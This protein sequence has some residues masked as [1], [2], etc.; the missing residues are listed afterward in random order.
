MRHT[1]E[2]WAAGFYAAYDVVTDGRKWIASFLGT[3][4]D[5]NGVPLLDFPTDNEA[6]ANRERAIACVNALAGLNPEAVR[7]AM[8]SFRDACY[9][10]Q[11][12]YDATIHCEHTRDA[13]NR[14]LNELGVED[15]FGN[16]MN[17]IL[18]RLEVDHE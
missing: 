12:V 6:R 13:V 3:H 7:E 8:E 4:E 17:T 11:A 10:A 16:R 2:P 1:K 14:A 5:E 18:A 15:G 9:V